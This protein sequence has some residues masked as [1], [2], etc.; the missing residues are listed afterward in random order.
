M[1]ETSPTCRLRALPGELQNLIFE[2]LDY[3]SAISLAATGRYFRN[4]VNPATQVPAEDKVAF[5]RYLVL[6]E[7]NDEVGACLGCFRIK[8]LMDV[9]MPCPENPVAR[10]RWCQDCRSED[11]DS[12]LSA[13]W[14][15]SVPWDF[16]CRHCNARR[17]RKSASGS[18][19]CG[20]LLERW[21]ARDLSSCYGYRPQGLALQFALTNGPWF[22][23]HRL[24]Y[25]TT[26]SRGREDSEDRPLPSW[27][28]FQKQW[29]YW[30]MIR[31]P[32]DVLVRRTLTLIHAVGSND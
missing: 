7:E 12:N 17:K 32:A 24:P 5:L 4:V 13:L 23:S 27:T 3:P 31:V 16:S 20:C 15:L 6:K 10:V 8:Q 11:V 9:S 29:K 22:F 26:I 19:I 18:T 14:S 25:R 1:A 21:R 28:Q 2:N 30:R